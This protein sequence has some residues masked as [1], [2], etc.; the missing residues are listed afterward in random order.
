M[1]YFEQSQLLQSLLSWLAGLSFITFV[2]SLLFIPYFIGLLAP[3]C[4]LKGSTTKKIRPP[5]TVGSLLLLIARNILGLLLTIAGIAMLFLPGQG[6]LTILLGILLLSFP[7]KYRLFARL[8]RHS[9]VRRSLN[10]L[11]KKRQ[12][13]PFIWPGSADDNT[14]N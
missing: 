13:P 12:K 1:D 4:F 2:L 11:R 14:R 5:L 7:G 6:L 3:D 9:S 10:W 8:V